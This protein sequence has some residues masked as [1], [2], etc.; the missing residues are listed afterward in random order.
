[1]LHFALYWRVL[2]ILS[3]LHDGNLH[4]VLSRYSVSDL[5]WIPSPHWWQ[6]GES[7]VFSTRHDPVKNCNIGSFHM[8][9]LT[10]I[11]KVKMIDNGN[12]YLGLPVGSNFC[13]SYC[14]ELGWS[15]R[16]QESLK[17]SGSFLL[18]VL[19]VRWLS[20]TYLEVVTEHLFECK[21]DH[22]FCSSLQSMFQ[23]P[24][25]V[26]V[27]WN[28]LKNFFFKEFWYCLYKSLF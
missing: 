7:C 22:W 15:P 17:K 6:K 27:G 8:S 11:L 2:E 19:I 26:R 1:M 25:G 24:Y 13:D 21:F 12:L 18:S 4:W 10:E 16:S 9:C 14:G 23:M 5:G 20:V 3:A 28:I